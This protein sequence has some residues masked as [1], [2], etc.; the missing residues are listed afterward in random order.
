MEPFLKGKH[1]KFG[2]FVCPRKKEMLYY[3]CEDMCKGTNHAAN[4]SRVTTP[5]T[6]P[7][8]DHKGACIEKVA[9]R[10]LA[11]SPRRSAY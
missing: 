11:I 8:V 7:V 6:P 10:R 2:E 4:K 1:L 3:S 5:K 9:G